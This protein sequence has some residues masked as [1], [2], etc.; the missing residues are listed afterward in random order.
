MSG[1]K[2]NALKLTLSGQKQKPKPLESVLISK[3]LE[4]ENLKK[5]PKI[6]EVE[7]EEIECEADDFN[8][9][10]TKRLVQNFEVSEPNKGNY[11]VKKGSY[12]LIIQ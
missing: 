7:E 10:L 12:C 11:T 9:L 8:T 1:D 6:V 4:F 2:T 5:N 3:K